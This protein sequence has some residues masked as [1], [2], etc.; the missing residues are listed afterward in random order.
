MLPIT[1]NCD[2]CG[3]RALHTPREN[4]WYTA[5]CIGC[6]WETS[7]KPLEGVV[8]GEEFLK[9][10]AERGVTHIVTLFDDQG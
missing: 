1:I 2:K 5:S 9:E 10:I 4:G 8:S 7:Y 6:G 3:L